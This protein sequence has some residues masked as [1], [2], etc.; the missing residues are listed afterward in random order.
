MTWKS[1]FGQLLSV[2]AVLALTSCG[3]GFNGDN[4]QSPI[5][6]QFTSQCNPY[7]NRGGG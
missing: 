1:R 5:A 2:F 6:A 7:L 3:H 4:C